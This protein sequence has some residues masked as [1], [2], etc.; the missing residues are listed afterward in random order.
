LIGDLWFSPTIMAAENE[1]L[2]RHLER[3]PVP[4]FRALK[5]LLDA[6][7]QCLD[8]VAIEL[9]GQMPARMPLHR[10]MRALPN[11]LVILRDTVP[12]TESRNLMSNTDLLLVIDGPDDISVFLPSKLIDYLGAGVPILGIAPPGASADLLTRL[13]A[14]VAD[15][16]KPEAVA[17][18]LRSAIAEAAQR[19]KS[20]RSE[21]WGDAAIVDGYNI[22]D[23]SATLS[24]LVNDLLADTGCP[25]Q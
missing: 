8:G 2:L 11:G 6:D 25:T 3:S 13:R 18:A 22:T 9:V 7:R 4:L 12:Y 19:R 14:R 23:V 24:K 16:R 15:P 21:P 17:A 10:S 5:L 1:Y 20:P